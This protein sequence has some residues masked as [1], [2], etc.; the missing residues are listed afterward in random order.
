MTPVSHIFF[1]LRYL[2][3]SSV[4]S[5]PYHLPYSGA[6]SPEVWSGP[7]LL[8]L[9]PWLFPGILPTALWG[10]REGRCEDQQKRQSGGRGHL[11][12]T[13]ESHSVSFTSVFLAPSTHIHAGAHQLAVSSCPSCCPFPRPPSPWPRRSQGPFPSWLTW[14][15]VSD[16]V[17]N[18][19]RSL[20]HSPFHFLFMVDFTLYLL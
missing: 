9:P 15:G 14:E 2:R 4:P 12:L 19:P 11:P 17:S 10:W 8:D 3:I 18:Y 20:C 5:F 6:S 16:H 13:P 7:Q 1:L